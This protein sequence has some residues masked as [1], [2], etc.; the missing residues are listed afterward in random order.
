M[1]IDRVN[2][3]N[4]GIDRSQY[5]QGKDPVQAIHKEQA[6][7]SA[8]QDSIELSSTAR[9]MDRITDLVDQGRQERLNQVREMLESG[10]YH[11]TGEDI[12]RK[13]IEANRD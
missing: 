6:S 1:S 10:T 3:S 8:R 13:L 5:V 7:S 2:I 9:E 4:A 12:A 11:V